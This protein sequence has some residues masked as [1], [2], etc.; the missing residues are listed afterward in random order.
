MTTPDADTPALDRS[1]FRRRLW[2]ALGYAAV[3]LG[4]AGTVLPLLPTTPFLLLAAW[5][6]AKGSPAL[7]DRLYSDPRFGP[8]LRDW[9]AE[10]AIPRRAKV[11]ALAGMS[12]SWIIVALTSGKVFV[13][14]VS[15]ACMAMVAVYIVTRPSPSGRV[16]ASALQNEA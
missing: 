4:L 12:V 15:G 8:L 6:F 10:G 3:G 11:A 13:M 9:H 2:M 5:A 16:T 14:A 1:P 7:R